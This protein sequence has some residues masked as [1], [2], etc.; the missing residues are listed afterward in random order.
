MLLRNQKKTDVIQ[1]NFG[2]QGHKDVRPWI[3]K[4]MFSLFAVSPMT[5]L[6]AAISGFDYVPAWYCY[7]NME[8]VECSVIKV[9]NFSKIWTF[10]KWKLRLQLL[11]VIV[12]CLHLQRKQFL[13]LWE[14]L[15]TGIKNWMLNSN[16]STSELAMLIINFRN[17]LEQQ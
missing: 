17:S 4:H 13:Q 6:E 11:I 5:K 12:M 2:T 7:L 3:I 1:V 14:E 15:T 8:N 9:C 16:I 10:W